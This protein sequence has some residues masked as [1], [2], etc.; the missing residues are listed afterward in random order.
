MTPYD[1]GGINF[2]YLNEYKGEGLPIGGALN[3]TEPP[4]S[5]LAMVN[6]TYRGP[7]CEDY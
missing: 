6:S 3:F 1:P 5:N 7:L 4:I 2:Q